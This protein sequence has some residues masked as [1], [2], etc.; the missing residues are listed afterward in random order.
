[1]LLLV[2]LFPVGCTV[3]ETYFEGDGFHYT[4]LTLKKD[5]VF[6][7]ENFSDVGGTYI[8]KGKWTKDENRITLNSF[9]HPIL[10]PIPQLKK[11]N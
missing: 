9:E 5:R 4:Y 10:N 2:L 7:Y 1:L 3:T 11:L 6:T 8:I